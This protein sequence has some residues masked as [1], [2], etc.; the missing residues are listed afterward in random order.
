MT[1][2]S[3]TVGQF[4]VQSVVHAVVLAILVESLIQVW[5]IQSP[6]LQIKFRLLPLLLPLIY[7]PLFYFFYPPRA[8]TPFHQQTALLDSNQW[9][10]LRLFSGVQVWHLFVALLAVTFIYF[11]WREAVPAVRHYLRQQRIKLERVR[12]GQ[13]PKLD[14]ALANLTTARG[15]HLPQVFLANEDSPVIYSV[16]H[17]RVVLSAVTIELLDADEL[18]MV[19]AHEMS[20]LSGQARAVYLVSLGLRVAMCYNPVAI[21]IFHH[22]LSDSEKL[23]DDIAIAAAGKRLALGSGLLKVFRYGERESGAADEATVKEKWWPQ[24]GTVQDRASA[25]AVKQRMARI[26]KDEATPEASYPGFRLGLGV[27]MLMLLLF[28]V[29]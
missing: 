1:F 9:L 28:F 24:L 16:G 21:L 20:H 8:G 13:F 7:L 6:A 11:V 19:L 22:I 27:G 3:A 18:E 12:A 17:S 29:V 26:V 10:A 2:F 4:V 25:E 14:A 23:C 5:R 15:L